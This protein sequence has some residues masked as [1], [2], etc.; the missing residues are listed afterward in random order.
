MSELIPDLNKD[1]IANGHE[2][3]LRH[4]SV[5]C[6]VF[7]FHENE[8]KVLLLKW[9]D[10]G[11]WCLPGGFVR[12]EESLEQSVN[13]VLRVRT[14]LDNI[15]LRQ[16]HVFSD[17]GREKKKDQFRYAAQG[18]WLMERFISVGFYALVEFSKVSPEPDIFSEECR[19]WD[20]ESVPKMVFDHND[21][22][23]KALHVLRM[24]LNDHP[25][26]YELLPS[27]F[28]MPE[29]QKLYETILGKALDRRNFQKKMLALGILERL[30]E[31]KMGGAH[32]APYLY[33]FNKARYDKALRLGLRGGF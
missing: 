9:K 33:K 28:T 8:L 25:I 30:K 16:F 12:K 10:D 21:I 13:S 7:G 23:Q 20:V 19:W 22:F 29:L 26:G 3:Y 24:S 11:P 18:G 32:K 27:K 6:V 2:F 4:V 5:D 1:L 31:R 15:F 17:P 14:G